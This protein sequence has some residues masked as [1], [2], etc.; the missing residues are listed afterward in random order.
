MQRRFPMNIVFGVREKWREK[1]YTEL[2]SRKP[3]DAID[4]MD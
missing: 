3:I 4:G 1:N 2:R